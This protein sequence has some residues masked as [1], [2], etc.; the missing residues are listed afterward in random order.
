MRRFIGRKIFKEF[1]QLDGDAAHAEARRMFYG[2]DM[3]GG[4]YMP[5]AFAAALAMG[6][7]APGSMLMTIQRREAMYSPIFEKTPFIDGRDVAGWMNHGTNQ[8]NGQIYEGPRTDAAAGHAT[9]DVSRTFQGNQ[10]FWQDQNSWGPKFGYHGL[11]I[12]SEQYDEFTG[13]EDV[14][15][16]V[17]EPEGWETWDGWKKWVIS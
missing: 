1:E 12:M 15:Y 17:V 8:E 14:K 10:N 7:F 13:L 16:Y 11:F 4:L 3:D 5:E 6:I 2:G 9:W